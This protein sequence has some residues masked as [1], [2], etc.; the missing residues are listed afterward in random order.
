M[1]LK[2]PEEHSPCLLFN[3]GKHCSEECQ[4][5]YNPKAYIYAAILKF[6][7]IQPKL[8]TYRWINPCK[9][10]VQSKKVNKCNPE[11]TC[12]FVIM[13]MHK[14]ELLKIVDVHEKKS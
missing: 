4:H 14:K 5:N 7:V 10:Y 8:P 3:D 2:W 6:F 12:L 1:V 9:I 11:L 13:H